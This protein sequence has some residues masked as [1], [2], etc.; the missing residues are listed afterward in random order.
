MSSRITARRRRKSGGRT[1]T[2]RA[3]TTENTVWGKNKQ[4]EAFWRK[5][6]SGKNVIL[7]YKD[8]THKRVALPK[9]ARPQFDLFDADDTIKA[10]LSS[11][12]SQDAYEL[13]LYPKAKN[14]SVDYVI[15]H[16]TKYFKAM[17]SPTR[18]GAPQMKKVM[19]PQ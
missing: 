3:T 14:K 18:E 16:Y 10:V 2:R 19:V 9:N 7:I 12:M 17:P 6:A 1:H 13:Y 4:L 8:G 15:R 5:L 11:N